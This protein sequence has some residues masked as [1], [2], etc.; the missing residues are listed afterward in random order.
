MYPA[1]P[2]RYTIIWH[3]AKQ[4]HRSTLLS[5]ANH[6][7]FDVYTP[8]FSCSDPTWQFAGQ[9]CADFVS[10]FGEEHCSDEMYSG[11]DADGNSVTATEACAV[12]CPQPAAE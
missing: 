10:S 5:L 8:L 11:E 2:Q 6:I 3:A 12:S 1:S 7:A 4:T 9:G